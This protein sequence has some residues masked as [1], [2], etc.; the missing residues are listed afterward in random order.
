[1]LQAAAPGSARAKITRSGGLR[2]SKAVPPGQPA[3]PA[4]PDSRNSKRRPPLPS[5]GRCANGPWAGTTPRRR[6]SGSPTASGHRCRGERHG[7]RPGWPAPSVMALPTSTNRSVM[8]LFQHVLGTPAGRPSWPRWLQAGVGGPLTDP[9]QIGAASTRQRT[10]ASSL[11]QAAMTKWPESKSPAMHGADGKQGVAPA[12]CCLGIRFSRGCLSSCNGR[13]RIRAGIRAIC[14]SAA[15][16]LAFGFHRTS[17]PVP[18]APVPG[19]PRPIPKASVVLS[20]ER[21]D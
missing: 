4:W 21:E 17:L 8:R 11:Q 7:Q 14:V 19:C 3:R 6:R 5:Q 20:L 18:T 10:G 9:W 1:V 13:A 15:D 16:P 12:V 2:H